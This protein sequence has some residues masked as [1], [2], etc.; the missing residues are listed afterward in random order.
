M[1]SS[2]WSD[3]EVEQLKA[4]VNH[5]TIAQIANR[6]GR[7]YS[8][9][10]EKAAE[11][12]SAQVKR[13]PTSIKYSR[14]KITEYLQ[15][16]EQE[17]KSLN[18]FAKENNLKTDNLTNAIK[19]FFPDWM[20]AY[21]ARNAIKPKT[22]CP[23][24]NEDFW[25]LSNKQVFCSRRCADTN[26]VDQSYFGGRRKE[27]IGLNEGICQLCNQHKHKGLSSHH[28]KGKENDPDNEHLIALCSGCH[29][30]VTLL[31]GRRF[32]A[33][34]EAWEVLIQLVLLRKN[35]HDPEYQR[36]FTAVKI[37]PI[38]AQNPAL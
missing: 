25:P 26:R 2:D 17:P 18:K 9:V 3:A 33:T 1:Q 22:K 16:L 13:K 15:L 5:L 34:E 24:C 20:E 7:T 32:A 27:T 21:G 38:Y 6:L 29:N 35:G 8:S 30:I 12:T 28:I 23:Y 14:P 31:A 19:R 10:A 11:Y 37:K 36:V 4:W